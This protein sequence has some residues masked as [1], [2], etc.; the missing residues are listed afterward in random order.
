MINEP[1][2]RYADVPIDLLSKHEV[3]TKSLSLRR[4]A[5]SVECNDAVIC[6][7]PRQGCFVGNKHDVRNAPSLRR[8]VLL[9][10]KTSDTMPPHPVGVICW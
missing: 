6:N 9:V 2:C 8:S 3:Y 10:V 4:S 1:K 5:L 7:S